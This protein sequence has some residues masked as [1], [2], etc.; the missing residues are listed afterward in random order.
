MA[1]YKIKNFNQD[2]RKQIN[3][4][5][6]KNLLAGISTKEGIDRIMNY[7]YSLENY[8]DKSIEVYCEFFMGVVYLDAYKMY[9]YRQKQGI[10]TEDDIDTFYQLWNIVDFNDLLAEISSNIGLFNTMIKASYDFYNLT[11]LGKVLVVRSLSLSENKKLSVI[12]PCHNLDLDTYYETITID[13]LVKN[14]KNQ[15][16]YY[17]KTLMIDFP[18]GV[19]YNV[20]GF[21]KNLFNIDNSNAKS[22]CLEIALVDYRAAKYLV[23]SGEEN[24]TLKEHIVFYENNSLEKILSLLGQDSELLF[25]AIYMLVDLYVNGRYNEIEFNDQMIIKAGNE[26]VVKKLTFDPKQNKE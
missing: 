20:V 18:E 3:T 11:G 9:A 10:A 7:L 12:F 8:T 5:I 14:I 16:K 25:D 17:S 13:R 4:I 21:I 22:L 19:I 1:E 26:E 6:E 2:I 15:F 23:N 24:E